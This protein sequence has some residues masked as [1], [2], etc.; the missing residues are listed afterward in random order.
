M[1][2]QTRRDF[3]VHTVS[4][5]AAVGAGLGVFDSTSL[6]ATAEIPRRTLGKTGEKV[7]AICLGG[8]HIG[9]PK[10]PDDGI[11]IID[12]AI[13]RGINFL[14]NS[15]DYHAGESEVRMGKAIQGKRD[16]VFLM[17]KPH[18]RDNSRSRLGAKRPPRSE[19][20]P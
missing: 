8:Y 12:A 15:D 20:R 2:G 13:D 6:A 19:P 10:N 17:T 9:I 18:P 7:S 4:G 5:A 11:R 1:S 14:D 3:L 16:K